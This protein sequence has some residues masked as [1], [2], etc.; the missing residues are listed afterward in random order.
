MKTN[1]HRN[2]GIANVAESIG[3]STTHISRL[4]R[5]CRDSTL[6]EYLED[7]RLKKAMELLFQ[8]K[9]SVAR[10]AKDSGFSEQQL[11]L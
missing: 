4:F 5:R 8:G 2:I 11:L 9:L 10:V 1:F 6:H 7:L 3:T